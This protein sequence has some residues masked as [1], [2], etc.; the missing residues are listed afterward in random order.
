M[1]ADDVGHRGGDLL[2]VADVARVH[3]RRGGARLGAA[4]R[5]LVE[6]VPAAGQELH[7][8]ASLGRP[9]RDLEP[10]AAGGAGDQD[11]VVGGDHGSA[12]P[13][14]DPRTR[15]RAPGRPP[16]AAATAAARMP[17]LR[18]GYRPTAMTR[19]RADRHPTE[20]PRM[21]SPEHTQR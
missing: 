14:A 7:V 12:V 10:D 9:P 20:E 19:T 6:A 13:T 11:H 17:R 3:L 8:R 18:A 16:R 5:S 21:Q 15:R 2:V 1:A 4:G